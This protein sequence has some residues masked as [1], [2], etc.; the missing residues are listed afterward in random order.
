MNFPSLN[1]APLPLAR[2][3]LALLQAAAL[4]GLHHSIEAGRW[5]ATDPGW[6]LPAYLVSVLL[7]LTLLVLADHWRTQTLWVSAAALTL[8]CVLAGQNIA[9][10]VRINADGIDERYP[11]AF[12]GALLPVVLAWLI[13]LPWLRARL[14][15]GQWL[16]PYPELFRIVWRTCLS[17]AE[18]ALFTLLFWALLALGA[19]LLDTL[20]ITLIKEWITDP[21][22]AYPATT[23]AVALAIHLIG[24]TDR[25]IDGVLQQLLGL[26][27]WLLPLA[28]LIVI[29]FTF[30]L[31]PRLPTLWINGQ[32]VM[33]S[34]W[35]LWLV[36]ATVL[37]FNAAFSDGER[38]PV[39][40]RWL[41]LALRAVPPLLVVVAATALFSITVR[42]LD[43]GLTVPRYWALVTAMFALL[44]SAGYA[45]AALRP[46]RWLAG[47][48]PVNITLAVALVAVVLLSLTPPANP[49]QLAIRSQTALAQSQNPAAR[50]GARAFLAFEGSEAERYRVW[51]STLRIMPGAEIDPSLETRLREEFQRTPRLLAGPTK[52][53]RPALLWLDMDSDGG[54]DALLVTGAKDYRLFTRS[55]AGWALQS[56][57]WLRE[58]PER[59]RQST[60]AP[61]EAFDTALQ[62]GDFGTLPPVVQELRAGAHRYQLQPVLR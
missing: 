5:P 51:R 43:L 11:V 14:E 40:G 44:Y 62:D 17:L 15:T 32:R 53:P 42:V 49:L 2:I 12:A 59:G 22:F 3:A 21:R 10:G 37:L 23:V 9:L 41:A 1:S 24:R 34:A 18:A 45:V 55:D 36:A 33:D 61:R 57:G 28:A 50:E 6:L 35:L 26:M 7:P 4:W 54:R 60:L 39:Y 19:A 20:G 13:A 56:G 31:L 29:V 52:G 30:A 25:L 46:G 8:V 16:P 38:P 47:M 48:A 27:Q 58:I